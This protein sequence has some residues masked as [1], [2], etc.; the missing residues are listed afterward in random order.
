MR[1]YLE[2]T[3][4][5]NPMNVMRWD[6][7]YYNTPPILISKKTQKT[8]RK[9]GSIWQLLIL[10]KIHSVNST[11]FSR[12]CSKYLISI[13]NRHSNKYHFEWYS[14]IH[15][16]MC[17]ADTASFSYPP[18]LPGKSQTEL[19]ETCRFICNSPSSL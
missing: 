19:H 8:M 17:A 18:N 4:L 16:Q 10:K 6:L 12:Q 15:K 7:N 5:E 11:L 2:K 9:I 1:K 3:Y 14:S 13:A